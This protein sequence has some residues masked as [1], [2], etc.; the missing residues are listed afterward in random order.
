MV[1]KNVDEVEKERIIENG[2]ENTIKQNIL[3]VTDETP[4]FSMRRFTVG[5]GGYTFYHSHDYEH[6]VYIL[7][8]CGLLKTKTKV[9]KIREDMAILIMPNEI[10]QFVNDGDEPLVLLCIIPN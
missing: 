2:V 9:E 10:H 4:N 5:P 3:S 1:V 7:S 6:E 8:G